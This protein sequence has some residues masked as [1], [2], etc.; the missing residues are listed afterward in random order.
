[1]QTAQVQCQWE[2][3]SVVMQDGEVH[4]EW[5]VGSHVCFEVGVSIPGGHHP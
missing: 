4:G 2:K 3:A 1:M 5:L